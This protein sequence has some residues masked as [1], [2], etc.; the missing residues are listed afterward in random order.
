MS[1]GFLSDTLDDPYAQDCGRCD[2]CVEPWLSM[3]ISDDA[4]GHAAR[5]LSRPG[6][7][8]APRRMWPTGLA[9]MGI[10]LKGR[11]T[12]PA[13]PG[14]ALARLTDLGWVPTLRELQDPD[15]KSVV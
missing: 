4:R 8:L 13:E 12:Q 7:A 1:H 3:D 6:V 9:N 11:I 15:R 14:R 10:R 2:N 5:V